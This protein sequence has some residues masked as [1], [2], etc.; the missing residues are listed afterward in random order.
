ML[1][2]T[3]PIEIFPKFF[4]FLS[5]RFLFTPPQPNISHF[6][7]APPHPIFSGYFSILYLYQAVTFTFFP[8]GW[9]IFTF[10]FI[11]TAFF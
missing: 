4:F 2:I 6:L 9:L 1:Y 8:L 7:F 10:R 5:Y 11:C 3:I